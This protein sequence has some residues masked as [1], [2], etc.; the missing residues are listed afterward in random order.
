MREVRRKSIPSFIQRTHCTINTALYC[1]VS[2]RAT[3]QRW[4]FPIL[5]SF[6]QWFMHVLVVIRASQ[7]T[8]SAAP[9][10]GFTFT[11]LPIA[12][13]F[14]PYTPICKSALPSL[15]RL[16]YCNTHTFIWRIHSF[17]INCARKRE[18]NFVFCSFFL[19]K[20]QRTTDTSC[21]R[22]ARAQSARPNSFSCGIPS[23]WK[24]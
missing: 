8:G 14:L 19:R 13:S 11:R 7:H 3:S 20:T 5:F 4:D 22:M 21:T 1:T 16:I 10:D 15:S 9:S 24:F 2:R 18:I 23:Q 12:S 6:F 17:E